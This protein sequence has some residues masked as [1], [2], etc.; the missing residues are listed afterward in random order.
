MRDL[1][2][3]QQDQQYWLSRGQLTALAVTTLSVAVLG[4][5]VGLMVGRRTHPEPVAEV[6]ARLVEPEVEQ[7]ALMDLLARVEQA[8]ARQLPEAQAASL[9]YPE[10]L[11]AADLP[12][13]EPVKEPEPQAEPTVIRV[14]ADA[15]AAPEPPPAEPEPGEDV[16]VFAPPTEGWSVQVAAYTSA[17]EADARVAAL[18]TQDLEAWRAEALVNGRTWYRVRIGAHPSRDLA[19][20]AA[21]DIGVQLGTDDL[22]VARIE[23]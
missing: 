1:N 5:F 11:I 13:Q 12:A 23:R 15:D 9:S 4:F 10:R 17:D 18:R 7:D 21:R 6:T 14:E 22:M 3:I 2:R 8:A 16:D 19:Q 20:S